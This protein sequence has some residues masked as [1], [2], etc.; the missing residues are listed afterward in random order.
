MIKEKQFLKSVN[1]ISDSFI[2]RLIGNRNELVAI[3]TFIA[4]M[5]VNVKTVKYT[6]C[7]ITKVDFEKNTISFRVSDVN[8]DLA[9]VK[10]DNIQIIYSNTEEVICEYYDI[11]EYG[12]GTE[13]NFVF[14][15]Y[16]DLLPNKNNL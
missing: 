15:L 6:K 3:C 12:S 2:D 4:P 1:E 14:S 9:C 16:L 11:G 13:I 7:K 10:L 5:S 8:N